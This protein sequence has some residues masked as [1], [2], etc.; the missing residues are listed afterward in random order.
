MP[1]SHLYCISRPIRPT[2]RLDHKESTYSIFHLSTTNFFNQKIAG[3]LYRFISNSNLF[4]EIGGCLVNETCF[5]GIWLPDSPMPET[6]TKS[7]FPSYSLE[8][9]NHLSFSFKG[10]ICRVRFNA[11]ANERRTF[12]VFVSNAK[13]N[14]RCIRCSISLCLNKS[15]N[16]S[17]ESFTKKLNRVL[18]IFRWKSKVL[19]QIEY[20][21]IVWEVRVSHY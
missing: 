7:F 12:W 17:H 8:P 9:L 6:S 15:W 1:L 2:Q 13:Q 19:V 21:L 10:M 20:L 18:L 4:S 3:S 11:K 14:V 16:Y 5:Y